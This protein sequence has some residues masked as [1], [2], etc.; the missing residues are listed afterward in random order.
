MK[1][2]KVAAVEPKKTVAGAKRSLCL[3]DFVTLT[4]SGIKINFHAKPGAKTS[5]LSDISEEGIGI[6]IG[7]PPKDGEANS[8]LVEYL[9]QV[10]FL[11]SFFL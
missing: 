8:E 9:A 4:K 7:A 10:F 3:E 6:R 2:G 1:K 11:C 5:S